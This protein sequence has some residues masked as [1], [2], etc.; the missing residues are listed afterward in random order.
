MKDSPGNVQV[1]SRRNHKDMIGLRAS[2]AGHLRYGH[3]A[4]LR[5]QLGQ[6]TLV[7]RIEML[8]QHECQTG[9]VRE[10]AE[11]FR[12]RLQSTGRSSDTYD[13]EGG[14]GLA[15]ENG[16]YGR[17][18]ILSGRGWW[19]RG[20]IR[21]TRG[22]RHNAL[23]MATSLLCQMP[24]RPFS[25]EQRALYQTRRATSNARGGPPSEP[26]QRRCPFLAT[27]GQPLE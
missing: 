8:N 4:C 24:P 6:V 17:N 18:G 14:T 19:R 7:T 25:P 3:S 22:R 1:A 5:E 21:R 10:M 13:S 16:P 15:C 11:Q 26:S 12:E 27:G 23:R 9:I 20:R 2:L